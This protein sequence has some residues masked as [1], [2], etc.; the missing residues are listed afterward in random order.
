MMG[1]VAAALIAVWLFTAPEILMAKTSKAAIAKLV[2]TLDDHP[3]PLHS[4]ITPSVEQL[5][6]VGLPGGAAVVDL[7]DSPNGRTRLHAQRV[8]EGVVMRRN[9]WVPGHGFP[10]RSDEE[11]TRQL[12]KAN[13]DYRWDAPA[14]QRAA[15]TAKWREWLKLASEQDDKA[16]RSP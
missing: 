1:R 3:N 7:L 14:E 2:H 6:E 10:D 15:A 9:G 11:K 4:D 13:G 5:I 8:V 12:L 16:G